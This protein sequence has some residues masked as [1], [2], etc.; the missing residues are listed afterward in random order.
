[1]D[2]CLIVTGTTEELVA[3]LEDKGVRIELGPVR[4]TGALGAME[5]V[6]LRDPDGNLL[7]LSMYESMPQAH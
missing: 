2:L 7:E 5:S 1:A 3:D 6:Y 4:R